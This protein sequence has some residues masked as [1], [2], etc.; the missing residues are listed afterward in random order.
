M[1]EGDRIRIFRIIDPRSS[2]VSYET[3]EPLP[4]RVS[5]RVATCPELLELFELAKSGK[6]QIL[7]DDLHEG[8][9]LGVI[10]RQ[11]IYQKCAPPEHFK[12]PPARK[13]R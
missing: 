10:G 9:T 6:A 7:H 11:A 1:P 3:T 2:R 8:R 4:D 13:L 12:V 5:A